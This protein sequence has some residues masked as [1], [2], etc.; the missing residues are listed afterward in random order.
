MNDIQV[1]GSSLKGKLKAVIPLVIILI[2]LAGMAGVLLGMELGVEPSMGM[3]FLFKGAIASLV[4]GLGSLP[5]A[6]LGGFLLGFAENFGVWK[7]QGEW[8]EAI[9]FGLLIV[10]LLFRSA[11]ILPRK[12]MREF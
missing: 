5:G 4:G 9:A 8:R 10:F 7:L 3:I 12:G 11:G 1:S 6:V 2:A